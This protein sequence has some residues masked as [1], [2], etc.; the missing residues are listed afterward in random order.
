MGATPSSQTRRS[1]SG[2]TWAP[3]SRRTK[4]CRA[5]W[6]ARKSRW[7]GARASTYASQLPSQSARRAGQLCSSLLTLTP[8]SLCVRSQHGGGYSYRLCKADQELTEECFQKTPLAF[9]KTKQTLVWNTKN[10]PTQAGAP[11]PPTPANGT[12]RLPVPKPVFVDEGTWPK[13]SMWARDPI[14]RIQDGRAGL[15]PH[16]AAQGGHCTHGSRGYVNYTACY[17]FEP[18]C[19]F[20]NGELPCDPKTTHCDGNGMGACSDDWVVGLISDEVIIPKGIEPGHWVLGWRW[21]CEYP[22][23]STI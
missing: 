21:D 12:L 7:R 16:T 11:K 19:D 17:A 1:L 2:E 14:P 5:G 15:H 3:S 13:G 23:S 6:L 8:A 4:S 20:D 18:P 9:D 22:F 10:V